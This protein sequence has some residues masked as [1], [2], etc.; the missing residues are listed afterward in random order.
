[1]SKQSILKWGNSLGFRL[2]AE[3]AKQMNVAEG[4]QVTYKL[5]GR[6][7]IIE[8]AAPDLPPFT[9]ADLAKA[10]RRSKPRMA[11]LGKPKGMET[12]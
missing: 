12:P 7:L 4:A 1:M 6:Q 2:P 8:P 3:V 5:N 10:I 9:E 11:P